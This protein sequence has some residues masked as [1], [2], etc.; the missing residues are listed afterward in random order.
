LRIAFN[1]FGEYV[2]F[3]NPNACAASCDLCLRVCPFSGESDDEDVLGK[4][5]F[6][7]VPG[8]RHASETGHYLRTVLGYSAADAHRANGASGG[9][10]TWTL[11]TLLARGLVDRVVC[12][13][14]VR[15]ADRAMKFTMCST[16]EEVRAASRSAYY[17]VE[18]SEMIQSILSDKGRYAITVLPCFAKA[19]RQAVERIPKLRERVAFVLGL[20]CGGGKSK[21][22]AEHICAM[23]GGDAHRL[24]RVTFRIKD[25]ERPASDHGTQCTSAAGTPEEHAC[26][27]FG[28][29]G[30]SLAWTHWYFTPVACGFCD[31]GFAELADGAFMDAWRPGFMEDPG[32]HSIVIL[33]NQTLSDLFRDGMASGAIAIRDVDI[34]EAIAS[35][36]NMLHF[37]RTLIRERIRLAAEMG[38]RVPPKRSHRFAPRVRYL[39]KAVVRARWDTCR[40]SRKQW[41]EADKDLARFRRAMAPYAA[42]VERARQISKA[43]YRP[44]AIPAALWRRVRNLLGR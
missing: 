35:Q 34:A 11:E 26:T 6:G 9:L 5:C 1:A 30:P 15:E 19:I 32:G 12:V 7:D 18:L 14:P 16:G 33:R 41:V 42:R 27:V 2:A 29:E 31:D 3:E 28:S 10:L 23:G 44:Q 22:Y 40:Q 8:M 38:Q 24:D 36:P 25:L 37:K 43:V 21:F 20:A 13:S 39:E 17:P 4:R